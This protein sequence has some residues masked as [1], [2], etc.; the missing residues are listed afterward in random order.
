VCVHNKRAAWGCEAGRIA[1]NCIN[2]ASPRRVFEAAK[3]GSM[4]LT[5]GTHIQLGRIPLRSFDGSCGMN[6]LRPLRIELLL[7]SL[8]RAGMEVVTAT[9]ARGLRTRG[10]DVGFTC[11]EELGEIGSELRAEGFRVSVVVAPGLRPNVVPRELGDWLKRIR[12]D[13]V[14]AQSGVWLKAVQAARWASVP[15]TVLTLH[16][17][18]PTVPWHMRQ[19][20]RVAARRADQVVAVSATLQQY[21][22]NEVRVPRQKVQLVENGV[23]TDQ[24][25]PTGRSAGFRMAAGVPSDAR[26]IGTVARLHPVKNHEMLIRAF[27]NVRSRIP[28]AF[29]LLVGDG[30]QRL[31]VEDQVQRL[32][33]SDAVRITGVVP[34]ATP[35]L[36]EM[37]VFALPSHI[38]GLS[39]SLLEAMACE[40]PIVATA[41]GGTPALLRHGQ[42]G[43]L[44]PAGDADAFADAVVSVLTGPC[45][46]NRTQAA[47][48]IVET[49][50]SVRKM[51]SE[52]ERVYGLSEALPQRI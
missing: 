52:Y 28:N 39:I 16:G 30:S 41:V 38:E 43:S 26:V 24:I 1:L 5:S 48:A 35:F 6:G 46:R 45:V 27:A 13:V 44:T 31:A 47:R 42:I 17:I 32:G 36:N 40:V 8:P 21:L 3:W 33:L 2:P 20:M 29:L 49:H 19:Y 4:G 11:I 51:V 7:P 23:P 50:Y 10:H 37:D 18:P 25:R 22:I 34:D 12:P 9:L 14:H 15:T